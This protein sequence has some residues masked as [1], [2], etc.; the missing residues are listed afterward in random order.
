MCCSGGMLGVMVGTGYYLSYIVEEGIKCLSSIQTDW[1][2]LGGLYG[3][4][5]VCLAICW[6]YLVC[7]LE[8]KG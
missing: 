2:V 5:L 4:A 7:C 6:V 1:L 8:I 3:L